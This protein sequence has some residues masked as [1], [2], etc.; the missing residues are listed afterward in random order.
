MHT[1]TYE[2]IFYNDVYLWV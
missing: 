1:Q 2:V